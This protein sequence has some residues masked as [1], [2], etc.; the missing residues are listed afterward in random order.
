VGLAVLFVEDRAGLARCHFP[1]VRHLVVAARRQRPTVG[2]QRQMSDGKT[3]RRELTHFLA[4]A[5]IPHE[6]AILGAV[7][8]EQELT[9]R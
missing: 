3:L 2:R 5:P 7:A 1:E 8:G 4:R 6:D 9:V